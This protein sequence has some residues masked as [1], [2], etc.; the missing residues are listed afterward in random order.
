MKRQQICTESVSNAMKSYKEVI[1]AEA[2]RQRDLYESELFDIDDMYEFMG[3]FAKEMK[4][5]WD[6]HEVAEMYIIKSEAM[7]D[8]EDYALVSFKSNPEEFKLL[9]LSSRGC[10]DI[11]FIATMDEEDVEGY[12]VK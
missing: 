1:E 3:A 9:Y 4:R 8:C 12:G 10:S 11:C 7:L 5:Y 6:L 2:A